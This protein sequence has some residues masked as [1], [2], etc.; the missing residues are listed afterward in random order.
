[1]G[2][3]EVR[4]GGGR[5]WAAAMSDGFA[6]L[7]ALGARLAAAVA[8]RPGRGGAILLLAAVLAF[9]PGQLAL[10]PSDRDEAR[11]AQASRQMLQ[12]GDF[13][14]IRFQD[15]VR[16]KKP[17]GIYWLQSLAAA[18]FGGADAPISAF[19]LPSFLGAAAAVGLTAWAVTPLVGWPAAALAGAFMGLS[20]LLHVE[21]RIAKTDAMLLVSVLVAMGALARLQLGAAAARLAFPLLWAA[22]GAGAL[23]KG[24]II[25]LPVLGCLAWLCAAERSTAPL[26]AARPLP[27]LAIALAIAAPWLVA[28]TVKS[29]GAFW[30]ESVGADLLGKAVAAQKP[31][32][33][34]PPGAHLAA[35]WAA[36]W[37]WAAFVPFAVAWAWPRRRE[38]WARFLAGWV[39]PAWLVFEI[40]PTKLP[41]YVLP[42]YPALAALAALAL[43]SWRDWAAPGWARGAAFAVWA[44]PA[45]ALV[46]AALAGTPVIEGR[47]EPLALALAAP[48]AVLLGGA[49][50][51]L[52]RWRLPSFLGRA[53]AGALLCYAAMFAATLPSLGTGFVAPR[54]AAAAAAHRC[55]AT[56]PVALTGYREPSAV[57]LLGTDTRLTTGEGAA[58]ALRDGTAALAFV[59]IRDRAAFA[60][61]GGPTEPL[62]VIPGFNYSNGRR[63][64][65]ALFAPE[66][67][68]PACAP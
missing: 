26:R 64:E 37:P 52:W 55:G 15:D 42:T 54:L 41:H 29:G 28:I 66:G 67:R 16:Y 12:S 2:G 24:P 3:V 46:L 68:S 19:R 7:D 56:G 21:A 38:P 13:L 65:L 22:V 35:F 34:A 17:V 61:A 59:D 1:M 39:I 18:P 30:A 14:D 45:L 49:G 6:A 23:L 25:L 5:W 43:M 53:G 20:V 33:A 4:R 32:H 8:A 48:G 50:V 57:F 40:T 51:A 62:A 31:P 36:A 63:V 47:V 10:P 9:A 58:A 44:A 60:A 11:F 27:G